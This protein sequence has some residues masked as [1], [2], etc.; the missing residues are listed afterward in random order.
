MAAFS[1]IDVGLLLVPGLCHYCSA[2]LY[3]S[4]RRNFIVSH[5]DVE[6]K[7]GVSS[8]KQLVVCFR[9]CLVVEQRQKAGETLRR[10]AAFVRGT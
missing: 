8:C 2:N 9:Q 4:C 7:A 1:Y 5:T 10:F 3:V 6:V